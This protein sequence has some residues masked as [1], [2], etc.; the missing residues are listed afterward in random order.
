MKRQI[1]LVASLV[2]GLLAAMLTRV[3]ISSKEDEILRIKN[4]TYGP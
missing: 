1:V 2:V 4:R 3:Y